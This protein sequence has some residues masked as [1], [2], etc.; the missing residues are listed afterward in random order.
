MG[1]L[2]KFR[3]TKMILDD[4][5]CLDVLE[6]ILN[7]DDGTINVEVSIKKNLKEMFD[8]YLYNVHP[9]RLTIVPLI[10]KPNNYELKFLASITAVALRD[11]SENSKGIVRCSLMFHIKGAAFQEIRSELNNEI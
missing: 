7:L 4:D 5:L 2:E 9:S 3:N 6:G 1:F 11:Y 8:H 10:V